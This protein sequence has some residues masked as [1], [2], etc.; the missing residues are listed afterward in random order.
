[1]AALSQE[2]H[3]SASSK[4]PRGDRRD[5]EACDWMLKGT[6]EMDVEHDAF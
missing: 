4:A 2:A 5:G 1:M 6:L 3:R